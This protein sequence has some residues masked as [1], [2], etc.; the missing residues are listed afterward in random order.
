MIKRGMKLLEKKREEVADAEAMSGDEG[1]REMEDESE[2]EELEDA[3]KSEG[4]LTLKRN[5]VLTIASRGITSRYR[6]LMKDIQQ[7][8][9]H[10]RKESKMD[11]RDP[12]ARARTA[13]WTCRRRVAR[14]RSPR[15]S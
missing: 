10:T 3:G 7:L 5:R 9:P 15:R 8:L 6:H 13:A 1:D 4:T 2:E 11:A 12:I 14:P